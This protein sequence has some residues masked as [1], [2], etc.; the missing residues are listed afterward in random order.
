MDFV[1]VF[2]ILFEMGLLFKLI[3]QSARRGEGF[4]KREFSDFPLILFCEAARPCDLDGI[5][6]LLFVNFSH[7]ARHFVRLARQRIYYKEITF[8]N[9]KRFFADTFLESWPLSV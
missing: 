6:M 9:V 5:L 4:P 3:C 2:F 8:Q 7:E 1:Q